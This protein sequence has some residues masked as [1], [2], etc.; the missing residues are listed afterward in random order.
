MPAQDTQAAPTDPH[1][2][3]IPEAGERYYGLSRA[4]S[5]AAAKRGD[6]PV[7]KV[8]RRLV[9]PVGRLKQLFGETA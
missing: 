1:W 4:A 8:G 9:V 2:L 5:Y 6:I 7:I 3:P